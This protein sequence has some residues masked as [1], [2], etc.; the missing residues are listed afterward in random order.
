MHEYSLACSIAEICRQSAEKHN[1]SRIQ[2]VVLAVGPLA[3]VHRETLCFLFSEVAETYGAGR[4]QLIFRQQPL[5]VHCRRC[6]ATEVLD[7]PLQGFREIW[8]NPEGAALPVVCLR[9][10][11][12]EISYPGATRFEVEELE[13]E[14]PGDAA[15]D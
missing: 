11:S 7:P 15:G 12:A 1:L 14:G 8:H 10:G 9:C 4:P 5:R 13:G 2:S 6:G 3:A